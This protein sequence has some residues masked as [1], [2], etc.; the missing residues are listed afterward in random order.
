MKSSRPPTDLATAEEIDFATTPVTYEGFRQLARNPRLT[1]EEKIAFPVTYRRGHEDNIFEDIRRKLYRLE[2]RD[3]TVV[4]IGCGV[5]GLTDRVV[6]LCA[7]QGH[8]SGAC[9]F[10]VDVGACAQ[11]RAGDEGPR[12][13]PRMPPR[14]GAQQTA[15]RYV[16]LCYSVLHYVFLD[17]NLFRFVDSLMGL[18]RPGGLALLG[19]IPN[20]SKRKRFFSSENG[21]A[22]HKAFQATYEAPVVHHLAVEPDTIDDAV[23]AGLVARVQNAGCH[24][25]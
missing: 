19:D 20:V 7:N 14:S 5:G 15:G 16:V 4:D 24:G 3:Q 9:Y 11:R 18:L 6:A 23:L 22:F 17:T 2:E 12:T 8:R 10:P 13:Y 21:I 1:A 25:Y